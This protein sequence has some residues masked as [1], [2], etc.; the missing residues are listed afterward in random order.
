MKSLRRPVLFLLVGLFVFCFLPMIAFAAD[1]LPSVSDPNFFA[2]VYEA[3][4]K[5]NWQF[6]AAGIV[7]ALNSLL[8]WIDDVTGKDTWLDKGFWKWAMAILLSVLGA[9]A[10]RLLSSE[11]W[12]AASILQA[13]GQGLFVGLS[14]TGLFTG[15]QKAKELKE[16]S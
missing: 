9:I 11:P 16:G 3:F 6:V 10:T 12:S 1:P 5:E 4:T 7:I 2:R 8:I 13:A 14:A 15:A